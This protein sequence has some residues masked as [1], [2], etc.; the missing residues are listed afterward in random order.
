MMAT[1][2][3]NPNNDL[4]KRVNQLEER[5]DAFEAELNRL[6]GKLDSHYIE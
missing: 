4:E 5:V 2:D 6:K 3:S 1:Q